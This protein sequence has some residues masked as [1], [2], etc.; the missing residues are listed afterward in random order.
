MYFWVA[1]V[2]M[3]KH[4]VNMDVSVLFG[5]VSVDDFATTWALFK[6]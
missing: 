6:F 2:A 3:C 4:L 5:G 1:T